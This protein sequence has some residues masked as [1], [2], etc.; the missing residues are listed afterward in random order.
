[1]GEI[2]ALAKI[3]GTNSYTTHYAYKA[4]GQIDTITYPSSRV[5]TNHYDSIG[6]LSQVG[7]GTTNNYIHDVTYTPANQSSSFSY[8]N[9]VHAAYTYNDHLQLD[10]LRYYI[11][12]ST[13]VLSYTYGYG[14]SDNGQIRSIADGI[15]SALSTSYSYDGLGRLS[16]A[17]TADMSDSK[18]WRLSWTYDR[19]GNRLSQ[20]QS[21]GNIASANTSFIFNGHNQIAI[22]SCGVCSYDAS[23]NMIHDANHTY[24]FDAENRLIEVDHPGPA[25]T[26][27]GN[28]FRVR[29]TVSSAA[30]DYIFSGGRVIAE[31]DGGS[32]SKEYIYAGGILAVTL[33]GSA[34]PTYHHSDHL[35]NRLETDASASTVRTFGHL[36][37][38]ESWYEPTGTD[39]WKFT[40]DEHDAESNLEHTQYRQLSTGLARWLSPDPYS[41]SLS[42]DNPQS[43]NRYSY[44]RNSPI[45]RKDS[46]GLVDDGG[47][48]TTYG[49][50]NCNVGDGAGGGGGVIMGFNI[51]DAMAGGAGFSFGIGSG[52]NFT[53]GYEPLSPFQYQYTD[54]KGGKHVFDTFDEYAAWRVDFYYDRIAQDKADKKALKRLSV[55]VANV[56]RDQ[57]SSLK[58]SA[59]PPGFGQPGFTGEQDSFLLGPAAAQVTVNKVT[60]NVSL[61]V[62]TVQRIFLLQHGD[63]VNGTTPVTPELQNADSGRYGVT[64]V[65]GTDNLDGEDW[66]AP[67]GNVKWK[68]TVSLG[69]QTRT[70]SG[71]GSIDCRIPDPE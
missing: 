30:T 56:T 58:P 68:Y 66:G 46:L 7:D 11:G 45:D 37:F 10:T 12:S 23:G 13:N 22:T 63:R 34:V 54:E 28:G 1:M 69:N 43:L 55:F 40:G 27:D 49:P 52:G 17:Q 26:Y 59:I 47:C 51:W 70:I 21:A 20:T 18:S 38:G 29:K 71:K 61:N 6:R 44:A 48:G 33:T 60:A 3:I 25:Y 53:W 5:V 62:F 2:T 41:G 67:R 14:A 36:P 31:Y 4:D 8:A 39:K 16:H 35:S 15:N 64:F 32:L 42:L 57:C 19:Y 50:I 9:G 24:A 65:G